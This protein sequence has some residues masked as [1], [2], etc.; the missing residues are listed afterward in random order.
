M[1]RQCYGCGVNPAVVLVGVERM[2]GRFC[3]DCSRKISYTLG[4]YIVFS[5]G[6]D[7]YRK[8][9]WEPS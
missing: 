1:N 7:F 9:E 3:R 8:G 5:Q 6:S 2:Q 4:R